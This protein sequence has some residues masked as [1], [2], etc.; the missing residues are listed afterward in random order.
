MWHSSVVCMPLPIS[1][2]C[3]LVDKVSINKH[4]IYQSMNEQFGRRYLGVVQQY[5][6]S[7]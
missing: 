5:D 1:I 3:M 2:F 7:V 4:K 6:G